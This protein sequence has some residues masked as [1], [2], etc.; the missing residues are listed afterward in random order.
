MEKSGVL[1]N[2]GNFRKHTILLKI[3]KKYQRPEGA[4]KESTFGI[5]FR[6]Q[7]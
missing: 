1:K 3:T 6:E 4:E 2:S 7:K 5:D